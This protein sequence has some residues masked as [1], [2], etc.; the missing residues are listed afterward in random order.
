V[1]RNAP[2]ATARNANRSDLAA[3]V[4]AAPN[5][6]YGVAAQQRAAQGQ[7]PMGPQPVAGGGTPAPSAPPAGQ[8][9]LASMLQ[10]HAAN[11]G[12]PHPQGFMRPTERPNEPVTHGIPGGAGAGPE[13]LSGVGGAARD[14]AIEQGTLQNLLGSMASSPGA[15]S[16]IQDLAARA[17]GGSL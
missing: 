7:I 3:P 16:A 10:A 12:G 1:P 14:G 2:R 11:G 9:D 15:T 13:V 6:P 17:Q 8:P 4:T 5:Q